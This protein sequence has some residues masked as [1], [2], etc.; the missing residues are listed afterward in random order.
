MI[1]GPGGIGKTRL[2]LEIASRRAGAYPDGAF[3]AEFAALVDPAL[4]EAVA[5]A[6]NLL[7]N[8]RRAPRG[9]TACI[10]SASVTCCCCSITASTLFKG[11]LSWPRRFLP[12]AR[13]FPSWRPAANPSGFPARP[14]GDWF[15]SQS[16]RP[17]PVPLTR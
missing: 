7:G 11:V 15:R 3:F 16:H 8:P 4:P 2:A 14:S 12:C 13:H 6:L 10:S 9:R 5:M 1:S 17:N